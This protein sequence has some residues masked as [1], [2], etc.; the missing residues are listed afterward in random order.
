MISTFFL[1]T[2]N[3]FVGLLLGLLPTGHLPADVATAI[4][5]F[6]YVVNSFS[7]V[8]PVGALLS[9]LLV[10]LAFDLAMLLWKM[11]NWII[12]KIPGMQ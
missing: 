12:K 2:F 9:A 10:I 3:S 6:W 7:Y 8:F 11:I 5:Y 1:S 4:T